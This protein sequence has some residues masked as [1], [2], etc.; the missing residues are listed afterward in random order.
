MDYS[1]HPPWQGVCGE[2]SLNPLNWTRKWRVER[3][4]SPFGYFKVGGG[5]LSC[6]GLVDLE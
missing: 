5:C 4:N 2:L 6:T 3:L 1:P